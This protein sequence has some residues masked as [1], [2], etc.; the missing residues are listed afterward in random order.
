MTISFKGIED[1]DPELVLLFPIASDLADLFESQLQC[2]GMKPSKTREEVAKCR[3]TM[4]I[5]TLFIENFLAS[6]HLSVLQMPRAQVILNRQLFEYFIR[7]QWFLFHASE[8]ADLL[9]SLPK[10]VHGEAKRANSLAPDAVAAIQ[11][12]YEEWEKTSPLSS[13]KIQ[14]VGVKE[15]VKELCQG[16]FDREYYY[17]YS[18]P[19]LLAHARP[20]GIPDVLKIVGPNQMERSPNSLWFNR[21]DALSQAIGLICQYSSLLVGHFDLETQRLNTLHSRFGKALVSLGQAPEQVAVK[22]RP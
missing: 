20:H 21:I 16:D 19:S 7:N 3:W 2:I 18:V 10:I 15:M 1:S 22:Y 14:D 6:I 12:Q 11:K 13:L 9:D 8:G 5:G 17:L 4:Y